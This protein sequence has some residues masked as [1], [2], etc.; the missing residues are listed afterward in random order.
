M[1][2]QRQAISYKSTHTYRKK[3]NFIL[4]VL[5]FFIYKV[6]HS[7]QNCRST[8]FICCTSTMPLSLKHRFLLVKCCYQCDSSELCA[9]KQFQTIR[10]LRNP[11][12]VSGLKKFTEKFE[13]TSVLSNYMGKEACPYKRNLL[14]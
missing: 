4:L 9:L 8:M 10:G 6:S 12:T 7:P 1:V 5:L 13:T 2:C 3:C 11:V 14:H